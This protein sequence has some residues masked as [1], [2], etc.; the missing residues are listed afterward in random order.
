MLA[1]ANTPRPIID[2][3]TK[4]VETALADPAI[5]NRYTELGYQ[6]PRKIGPEAMAEFLAAE[7]AK[8]GPLAK[9]TGTGT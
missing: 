5:Q 1:P 3:I 7:S 2:R 6:M 9:A 8:W 4:A